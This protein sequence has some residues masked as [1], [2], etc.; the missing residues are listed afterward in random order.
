MA[1]KENGGRKVTVNFRKSQDYRIFAATDIY[2]GPTADGA[3][4]FFHMTIDHFPTPSYQTFAVN[5]DGRVNLADVKETVSAG[6][7]E[8]E[9]LCGVLL[10]PDVAIKVGNWLIQR[11]NQLKE[12]KK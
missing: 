4:V 6:D 10:T 9:L 12:L 11:G 3:A 5:S 1:E 8:K 7:V 2:G